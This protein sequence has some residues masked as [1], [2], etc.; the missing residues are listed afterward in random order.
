MG[1]K[2]GLLIRPD[3]FGFREHLQAQLPPSFDLE[4]T[5]R[6]RG[7]FR[8]ARGIKNAATL[9]QL[10]MAYGGCGMSLRET[11][12]WAAAVGLAELKDPLAARAA[13]QCCPMARGYCG[14]LAGA[15]T[16]HAAGEAVGRVSLARARRH[17]DLPARRRPHVVAP[18]CRLRSGE[19]TG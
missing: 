8:R 11:C 3:I 16:G 5:A 19:R 14:S 2:I 12:A 1:F 7:A 4:Q 9:L 10:A 17:G 18:A 6:T 13:L 15:A